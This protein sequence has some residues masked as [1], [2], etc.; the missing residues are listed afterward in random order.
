M[1]IL[2]I[3][4]SFLV[5]TC[6]SLTHPCHTE[7]G[8]TSDICRQLR[9]ICS[10]GDGELSICDQIAERVDIGF[11][12]IEPSADISLSSAS[13]FLSSLGNIPG[14]LYDFYTNFGFHVRRGFQTLQRNLRLNG[15]LSDL[16]NILP[17]SKADGISFVK[18]VNDD[19]SSPYS[20]NY[21]GEYQDK[22][23]NLHGYSYSISNK[24]GTQS[25]YLK[26]TTPTSPPHQTYQTN[27]IAWPKGKVSNHDNNNDMKIK[28]NFGSIDYDGNIILYSGEQDD[29]SQNHKYDNSYNS[30]YKNKYDNKK[31]K[32]YNELI[33]K[34]LQ[35]KREE[36]N[37]KQNIKNS[38]Y[39]ND[40]KQHLNK[41]S[42]KIRFT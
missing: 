7:T 19:P 18:N 9:D 26:F 37:T 17:K 4:A 23:K 13:N 5:T 11:A 32:E 29:P 16:S 3:T 8:K 31:L 42:G 28:D 6:S 30:N 38:I 27:I 40:F 1:I 10:E 14:D 21:S 24:N 41:Q 22:N 2:Y 12:I 20:I 39:R 25:G 33:V 36:E 15:I 34:L 35:Q